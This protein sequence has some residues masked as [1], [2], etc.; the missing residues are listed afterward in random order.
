MQHLYVHVPFCRRRCSYCDF[1]IAVRRRVPADHY[2]NAI[3][4]E[5]RLRLA[6]PA[7]RDQPLETLYL[8]GGTPSLLPHRQLS[9]LV[10]GLLTAVSDPVSGDLEV[11]LEANPDD[12]TAETA[13]AWVRM[14][15]N[16]VSLGVQSFHPQVL[17]WMHRTHKVEASE[18]AARVLRQAGD[19]SL[20]LDLIFGLP[21]EL[22][23]DFR[24]DLE[25]ALTLD[26][27][28]LSIYA[29]TTEPR[30]PLARW[31]ARG[32]VRGAPDSDFEGQF[33]LAHEVLTR[34]GYEH[35]E[36]SS[37]ARPGLA[38][39]HNTAYWSGHRYLGLGPSA[40]SFTGTERFWNVAQWAAYARALDESRDPTDSREHLTE[41]QRRLERAYLGLRTA[42]GAPRALLPGLGTAPAR[43]AIKERWLADE[44][45]RVRLT[46]H[47]WLRL[48]KLAAILTTKP[49][50]G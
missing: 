40:H 6:E 7:W 44:P 33:L 30:T 19:V 24:T 36:V 9:R 48:E 14:G 27:D 4:D 18:E 46:P 49:G 28:H 45:D 16:R 20:S 34:S 50:G 26:P 11:T 22:R 15:V 39:R 25:R 41:E 12:V 31:I 38:A 32:H 42:A 5:C 21:Q 43:A 13:D 37:Y 10:H 23:S 17:E 2:V 29:L 35:Y 3:L 1:A 47:G 8:G